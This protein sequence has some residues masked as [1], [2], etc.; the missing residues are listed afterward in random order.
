MK[1]GDPSGWDVPGTFGKN[2]GTWELVYNTVTDTI[3]HF[4]FT[5]PK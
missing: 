4:N 5:G 1:R 2:E 3:L